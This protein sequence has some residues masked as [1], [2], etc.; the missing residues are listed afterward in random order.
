VFFCVNVVANEDDAKKMM[1][2]ALISCACGAN[3]KI[4]P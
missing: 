1:T 4:S 3:F 2:S